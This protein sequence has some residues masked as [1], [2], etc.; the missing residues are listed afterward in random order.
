MA[1]N[2]LLVTFDTGSVYPSSK[3]SSKESLKQENDD[4]DSSEDL[5]DDYQFFRSIVKRNIFKLTSIKGGY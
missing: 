3:S 1:G 5:V 2:E 4:P